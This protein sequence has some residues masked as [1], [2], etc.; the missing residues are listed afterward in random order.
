[1]DG[2]REGQ[3]AFC[4]N[5]AFRGI[6]VCLTLSF[7]VSLCPWLSAEILRFGECTRWS[8]AVAQMLGHWHFDA[9]PGRKFPALC[10]Q[11]VKAPNCPIS[12][13]VVAGL[14]LLAQQS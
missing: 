1:M 6:S 8:P 14:C 7:F 10:F 13:I 9:R 2:G 4:R 11:A 3:A 12:F 5:S